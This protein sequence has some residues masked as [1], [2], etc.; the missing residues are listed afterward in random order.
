MKETYILDISWKT[1]WKFFLFFVFLY[2]VFLVRDI[3][4]WLI[5]AL[6]I[7]ILLDPAIEFLERKRIPRA[8]S[9]LL[10][11]FFFVFLLVIVIYF[12]ALPL[13]NE[14]QKITY[15]FPQYF[16]KLSPPLRKLGIEAFKDIESFIKSFQDWLLSASGGIVRAISTFFGGLFASLTILTLSVFISLEKNKLKEW[17]KIVFSDSKRTSVL[18]ILEKSQHQISAWFGVK[19]LGCIFVGVLTFI[20]LKILKIDYAVFLAIL[21]GVLNII[22]IIG[23]IIAG[24]TIV[25][26]AFFQSTISAILIFLIF[27][28]IQQIEGNILIPILSKKF[29]GMSP[30][31]VL[32]SLLIGG[33]LWGILGGIL[34]VPVFGIIFEFLKNLL[35]TKKELE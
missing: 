29:I 35:E 11:Y 19:I 6:I 16:E 31:L 8:V 26:F 4:S 13:F 1:I 21:A 2:L 18:E 25:L 20:S 28:V 23:P 5:F 22:P 12:S 9:T 15:F 10:I 27:F 30:L 24:T 7:S 32:I 17:I 33:K 3:L 14:L 34:A